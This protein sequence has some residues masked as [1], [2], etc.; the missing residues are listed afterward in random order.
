MVNN[1]SR[2]V[3]VIDAVFLFLQSRTPSTITIEVQ[4]VPEV[5]ELLCI[6]DFNNVRKRMSVSTLSLFSP[7]PWPHADY[8]FCVTLPP[9]IA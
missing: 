6:L 1:T 8:Y 9:I 3:V 2:L 7:S 5:Y 4:G